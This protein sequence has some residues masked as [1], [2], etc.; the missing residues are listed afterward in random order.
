MLNDLANNIEL[1][2]IT[3]SIMNEIVLKDNKI[4]EF[5]EPFMKSIYALIG[6]MTS[7]FKPSIP[8]VDQQKTI[9]KQYKKLLKAMND[10]AIR[11]VK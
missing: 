1:T 6:D 5:S 2:I 11:T 8:V 9:I 7:G 4:D 10:S 3:S